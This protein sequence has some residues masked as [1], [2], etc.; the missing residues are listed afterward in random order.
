MIVVGWFSKFRFE[1]EVVFFR[2][3]N[4][5][6]VVTRAALSSF[7]FR[8]SATKQLLQCQPR[9][10]SQMVNANAGRKNRPCTTLRPSAANTRNLGEKHE[11]RLRKREPFG[12]IIEWTKMPNHPLYAQ[13]STIFMKN[14]RL[15][16]QF[17]HVALIPL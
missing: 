11:R 17:E 8:I 4:V 2:L 7:L 15:L 12:T 1:R 3:I 13:K 6:F 16:S 5:V 10:A 9:V 14:T